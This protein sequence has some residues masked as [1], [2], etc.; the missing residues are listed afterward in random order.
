MVEIRVRGQLDTDWS[1]QLGGLAIA[2]VEER[3]TVLT[4]LVRDQAMLRGLLTEIADL[5]LDLVSV[6]T[7]P[8]TERG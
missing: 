2:Y 7:S 5:G 6:T 3:E 4:G 1:D 8:E